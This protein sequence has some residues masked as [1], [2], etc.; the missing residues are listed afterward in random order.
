MMNL[1]STYVRDYCTGRIELDRS[2][3]RENDDRCHRVDARPRL[4]RPW[5]GRIEI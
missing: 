4:N 2:R 3:H 1:L 5:S